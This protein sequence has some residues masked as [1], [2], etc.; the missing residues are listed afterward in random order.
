MNVQ[1]R[2][3][4]LPP[5]P[6]LYPKSASEESEG[7]PPPKLPPEVPRNQATPS[8]SLDEI[9]ADIETG[10]GERV[11]ILE[12]VYCFYAKGKWDR[13]QSRDRQ[14]ETSRSIWQ[15]A[16][17]DQVIKQQLFWRLALHYNRDKTPA[18]K[19]E[20]GS[21]PPRKNA[22]YHCE[23]R[24]D[25]EIPETQNSL[26]GEILPAS[27]A[28]CFAQFASQFNTGDRVTVD[29]LLALKKPK[30]AQ[31]IACLSFEHLL[32]PKDLLKAAELPQ[33]IEAIAEVF[34]AMV[35]KFAKQ[36]KPDPDWAKL[37]IQCLNEMSAKQ[38]LDGVEYLLLNLR[39]ELGERFPDL[40]KWLQNHY[41]ITTPESRWSELSTPA[42]EALKNWIGALN[43]G[44]SQ[45]L[46]KLLLKQL[47]LRDWESNQLQRRRDFWANYSDR[48]ERIRILLPAS[49]FISGK[50]TANNCSGKEEF[51]PMKGRSILKDY[52]PTTANTAAKLACQLLPLAKRKNATSSCSSGKR[53]CKKSKPPLIYFTNHPGIE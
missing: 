34:P 2:K 6:Q 40:V 1:F 33:E 27:L 30:A 52:T 41:G 51:I 11:T 23:S 20:N 13:G 7:M 35:R 36:A 22:G 8:R 16:L 53:K 37:L 48:F 42:K 39:K 3:L 49:S 10:K 9:L 25:R 15:F 32:T 14:E 38:Q 44:D 50:A 12:W 28:D 21:L 19:A 26:G 46:V 17:Y 18:L 5:L 45:K 24:G 29:I 47:N 31:K 4:Q 43:Y